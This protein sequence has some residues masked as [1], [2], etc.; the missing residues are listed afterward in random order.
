M[1]THGDHPLAHPQ[2]HP[3][4]T[5]PRKRPKHAHQDQHDPPD[6]YTRSEVSFQGELLEKVGVG[7]GKGEVAEIIG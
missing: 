7:K 4:E 3:T 2:S 5:Q 1:T 6:E